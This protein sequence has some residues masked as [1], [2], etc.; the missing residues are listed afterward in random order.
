MRMSKK[1]AIDRGGTLIDYIASINGKLTI[2]KTLSHSTNA[3][4]IFAA[5][6]S[7]IINGN[8]DLISHGTTIATKAILQRKGARTALNTTQGFRDILFIGRQHRP[9]LYALQP[10][11]PAPIIPRE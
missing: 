1:F 6:T 8:P 4:Q 7:Q 3:V 11:I 5:T 9:D 2:H 10:C